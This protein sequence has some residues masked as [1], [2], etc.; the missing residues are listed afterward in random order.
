MVR[1]YSVF[2]VRFTPNTRDLRVILDL[3][4]GEGSPV[5][6]GQK[7]IGGCKGPPGHRVNRAL[8]DPRVYRVRPVLKVKRVMRSCMFITP[9]AIAN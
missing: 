4:E 5:L 1:R 2:Q 8:R 7:E 6:Q 9:N 3:K